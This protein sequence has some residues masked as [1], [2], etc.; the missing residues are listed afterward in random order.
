[1]RAHPRPRHGRPSAVSQGHI[2]A[3]EASQ[4]QQRHQPGGCCIAPPAPLQ[5]APQ[6]H[7]APSIAL[8]GAP[9]PSGYSRQGAVAA[10]GRASRQLPHP[11][12]VPPQL[13]PSAAACSARGLRGPSCPH[14]RPR[15]RAAAVPGPAVLRNAVP[16]TFTCLL[17][18]PHPC[19]W[20]P[21]RASSAALASSGSSQAASACRGSA[22]QAKHPL[23]LSSSSPKR[24]RRG[25]AAGE[26]REMLLAAAARGKRERRVLAHCSLPRGSLTSPQLCLGSPASPA[27]SFLGSF[28][29][30]L[31][32][33]GLG[34]GVRCVYLHQWE[35][36]KGA[37][38]P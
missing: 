27:P 28:W 25:Q 23:V 17:A 13:L 2:T 15:S 11:P 1:M 14:P 26:L 34:M 10:K 12:P 33:R 35:R 38:T 20:G 24:L 6:G 3:A 21:P 9:R 37:P 5:A 29:G 16:V 36:G 18:T 7:R 30:E 8:A 4:G 22:C 32:G 31:G 19:G